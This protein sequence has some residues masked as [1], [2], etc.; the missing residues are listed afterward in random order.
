ME[1][2]ACRKV[3]PLPVERRSSIAKTLLVMKFIA[4]FF[5]AGCLQISAT[6]LAQNISL[7]EKS[8]SLKRVLKKIS[9]QS[10]VAFFYDE[11]LLK[12]SH[13]VDVNITNAP[14]KQALDLV[15]KDQ[16]ITYEIV[17]SKLVTLKERAPE[18]KQPLPSGTTAVSPPAD[19]VITGTVTNEKGEPM[20]GVTV[21]LKGTRYS[22]A[23]NKDGYYSIRLIN[24]ADSLA[25]SYVGYTAVSYRPGQ[26]TVLNI[27]LKPEFAVAEDIVV[28]GY[29]TQRK[30]N[31]TGSVASVKSDELTKAPVAST[32]NTLAGR[33]PGLVSLQSS[34]Q[35]GSDQA[36][37]SIRGFGQALWIVDG[38]E[39]DFNNI[40]PNSIESISILKDGSSSIYGARAGNGVIL[41]TTKR[42]LDQKPVIAANSS[43]TLQGITAMAKPVGSGQ[44]AELQNE[45]F[46]NQ[47]LTAPY[48]DQQ[49]Q[50]YYSGTDP[51][52]PNTDWYKETIRSW[53]PQTQQNISVRGG[54]DRIKYYGLVGYLDQESMWKSN[55]GTYYRYNVQSNIDA[56]IADNLLMQF[57]VSSI[58]ENRKFSI[59]SQGPG[60]NT[61]WQDLW[62]SLPIYPAAL[63][64]PTKYA[65]ANGQ[66]IGSIKLISDYNIAGYD[67]NN[68][69][70]LKG[71]FVLD[72]KIKAVPGLS[73]KGFFNYQQTYQTD[74]NFTKPYSFYTYDNTLKTYTLA[75][76]YGTQARLVMQDNQSKTLTGQLSLN[77]DHTFAQDHH[78]TVLALYEAID[79]STTF[80]QAGRDNFLTPAIEQLYAGAVQTSTATGSA[81]QMGRASYVGRLNYSYKNKYLLESSLRADASAKFPSN[82]RWGYFPSVSVG[83]RLD[84]ENFM[85]H[86][87]GVDELKLRASYGSS[88]LDNVGNF[89]YLTGYSFDGQWLIGSSTQVGLVS[90]GLANPNLTWE[91]IKIYN[92]GVD[93]SLWK[94]KVFGTFEAF[95]RDLQGIPATRVLSLPNTF[96]ATLPQ[97]NL[98]SQNNRGFELTLGTSGKMGRLSYEITG[99]LSWSRAKWGHYEEQDYTDPDQI[100]ILKLSGKWMD[101]AFG[102]RSDGLFTSQDEITKL[103]YTYPSGNTSLRPGDI[104][105][106]DVN[107]D[108]Q[109][110][111]R[112][113]IDMGKG[114]TPQW[115]T[116]ANINL[117]YKNFDFS[118]LFQGAFGY[119][120]YITLQH[121]GI[122][123]SQTLYKLRWSPKNNSAGAFIPRLSG[124]SSDGLTSDHFYKQAGY[125]RL[126][127]LAIGYKI[128][129]QILTQYK[130]QDIR[131][132]LAG[133]N[134]LTFNKLRKYDVDPE[135]PSG[136]A[137]YYYPQQRTITAGLNLTF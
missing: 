46:T 8:T 71:T 55:G 44:Y 116:G 92:A 66:G 28:V 22:V 81:T 106:V 67:Q 105:Y 128:P 48:T 137:G 89:Q 110:D 114:T 58:I 60:I 36:A 70:N 119:Y 125:V 31:L 108:G 59:R 102:Y 87:Y 132:Y 124:A 69:Q 2:I 6:T 24:G 82:R 98:N 16:G 126:K 73:A 42:G 104:K 50:K 14:L 96:G 77:Y 21:N 11:E 93:F 25:F 53:A 79:Y 75:G 109:L 86:S 127:T 45:L 47:G 121:G 34:G 111:W 91:T 26:R 134:L 23:T 88:G 51:Q 78:F 33:L 41:V 49:V 64:D 76:S 84:Q 5:F 4:L 56:R 13:P 27:R 32:I 43:Y 12:K 54:N 52:Y 99:N 35:P 29:G 30:V 1:F 7:S 120:N 17:S 80:L 122:N 131:F 103:K 9:N 118:A 117:K 97:E 63:P 113:Q 65:Y 94:R 129:R 72:Y 37:I 95:Y 83:W 62:N 10:G 135:S 123:Y 101:Q 115:M 57:N 107:G 40:D 68:S 18:I 112:D 20:M 19:T 38:V 74:K 133:T 136:N 3:L 85:N 130:I 90:T 39:S 15:F 100:R 61:V